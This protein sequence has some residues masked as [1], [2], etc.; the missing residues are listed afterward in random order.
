MKRPKL[1]FD[2]YVS[3]AEGGGTAREDGMKAQLRSWADARGYRVAWGPVECV[4]DARAEIARRHASGELD[5]AFYRAELELLAT[6]GLPRSGATVVVV[7][8]PAPAHR[9]RFR[10]SGTDVAAILPPT[11][12][13]YRPTFEEV[14]QDL[15]AHGL[16]GARVEHLGWPVKAVAARLGLARYGRNNV[17]YV[18][19]LGS[20]VQLCAFVT[21]AALPVEAGAAPAEPLLLD[22]CATCDACVS[23]CPTGAIDGERVLLRAERCM[24]FVNE[25]PGAWPAWMS[26]RWHNCLLGCLYCQQ[27]CPVN[28]EL[29]VIDTGVVFSEE[30]TDALLAEADTGGST[31]ET[32]IGAK[33]AWLG[34]PYAEPVLGRNLRALLAASGIA[35]I[36]TLQPRAPE[37][38]AG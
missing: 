29:K 15:V 25:N 13:R 16:A 6:G 20:Y 11:Y 8:K 26:E 35:P 1:I 31:G 23:A 34:Q 37:G 3:R 22:E 38:R 4:L 19:D 17:A 14:R 10:L 36:A 30:E 18:E 9:V 2:G 21:D 12:V 24:T 5:D 32:G 7:A 27:G 33:L 28:P